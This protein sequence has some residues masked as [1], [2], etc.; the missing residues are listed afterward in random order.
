MRLQPTTSGSP[1]HFS[2]RNHHSRHQ[3]LD[4]DLDLEHSAPTIQEADSQAAIATTFLLSSP[5]VCAFTNRRD[6][7]ATLPVDAPFGWLESDEIL[8]TAKGAI[9]LVGRQLRR[10]TQQRQILPSTVCRPTR[11]IEFW[12]FPDTRTTYHLVHYSP[13]SGRD[14]LKR[15]L[16]ELRQD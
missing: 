12:A 13:Q 9:W 15:S 4:I 16:A 11:S 10:V 5:N 1:L 6:I 3:I 14:L 2:A 8:G 7:A